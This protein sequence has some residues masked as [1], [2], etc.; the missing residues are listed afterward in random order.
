MN[1]DDSIP[2]RPSLLE[3]LKDREDQEGWQDFF[4]TYRKLIYGVARKAG[5]T[6]PEAQE[7]LQDTVI[8]VAKNL[9]DFTYDPAV[10][11]FKTWMLR[12][13]RWRIIDQ[14]RKRRSENEGPT[15]SPER[16]DNET[17]TTAT[18]DRIQEPAVSD[19]EAL[20]N[21]EWEKALLDVALERVKRQ[22]SPEQ[23]QM[24]DLYALKELPVTK[25]ASILGV[26]VPRVYVA[27]HRVAALV[28]QEVKALEAE[29]I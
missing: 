16:Q 19:L 15:C 10:C 25:V 21:E 7:V 12:L 8:S 3:R 24:F 18:M 11:S 26:S 17:A 13:T 14:L 22:V 28:K 1:L 6:D 4:E 29:L 27:K 23:Y 20:W 5:L 9:Q 2:T